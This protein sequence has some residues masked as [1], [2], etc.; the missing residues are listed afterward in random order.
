MR[1]GAFLYSFVLIIF[2]EAKM[3]ERFAK[4]LLGEGMSG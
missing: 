3:M 1:I 2:V 4:L